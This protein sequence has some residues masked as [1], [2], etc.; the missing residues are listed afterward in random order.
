MVASAFVF[1]VAAWAAHGRRLADA[2]SMTMA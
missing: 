2:H 1:C